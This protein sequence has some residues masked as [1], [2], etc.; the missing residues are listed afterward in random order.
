MLTE[1]MVGLLV[2]L[3]LLLAGMHVATAMF[4]IGVMAAWFFFGSTMFNPFGTMM[5]GTLNNFI[6]IAMPL[7]ILMGEILVRGGLA[8]KMYFSLSDWVHRFPGR[9]LHT[10]IATSCLFASISGS[11]IATAA[12]IGT[13]AFPTFRSRGY[14]DKWVLG[15]VA[16]GA[17]LGILIPPS[18]NMIIYG[19]MTDT[20][21]GKL[22]MAGFVPGFALAGLFMA[23]IAI[24]ALFRPQ[25]AG[26]REPVP[27]LMDRIRNLKG[28][29]PA[30][31]VIGI[32]MGSIYTG[33]ATPTE[34][35]AVGVVASLALAAIKGSL[36]VS[37]L[38]ESVLSAVNVTAMTVLILVAAFYLNFILGLIGVPEL[39]SNVVSGTGMQPWQIIF[40][41][42]IVYL[43][44]GCFIDTMTMM[45]ATIPIVSPIITN[46]GFDPV[47]AGIFIVIMCEI[48]LI[49]PP[50]GMNLYVV[51]GVR[52]RGSIL[53]VMKG[54]VPFLVC[55]LA[56][57][58]LM[59]IWPE[60]IM[61]L[62][63]LVF[64]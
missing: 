36:S 28:L 12:T 48:G 25:I 64:G 1:L 45:I 7:Y 9:L 18:V 17:T 49:T 43:I 13:V 11:S 51:Q 34:A 54:V 21:V 52:G 5:W 31:I 19:A 24:A 20:S 6:L 61:W 38:K 16:A 32:V 3:G 59:T 50:V 58:V 14:E 63:N 39:L 42:V 41:L 44:L 30:V 15:S 10:N 57:V 33:W 26:A 46:A 53:D 2:L 60:M 47:W 55:M 37:M 56:L 22:F 27:P 8:E 40:I 35:A 62:P 29:I 4:S 23:V